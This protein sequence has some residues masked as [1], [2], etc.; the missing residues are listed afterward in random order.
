M[1][2]FLFVGCDDS[3]VQN[4]VFFVLM[5]SVV[6]VLVKL[7]SQWDSFNGCIEVV[8]SVQFCFCVLGYID[9]VNYI[10]GQEVKKGQVLF[11]IDDRIYCVV[12]E[13]VQVV[14]VRVKMQVSFV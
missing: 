1:F 5:V 13:Q 7:I 12:L 9:K 8:E 2:F 11:M 6:K 4:V 3:V 14:L 10:D